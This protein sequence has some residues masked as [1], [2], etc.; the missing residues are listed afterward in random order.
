MTNS[1]HATAFS[2]LFHKKFYTV[3]SGEKDKGINVRIYEFLKKTGLEDRL[4]SDVPES[5]DPNEIEFTNA[6]R[7]ID[8]MRED[9]FRFLRTN[10]QRARRESTVCQ[11]AEDH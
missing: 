9:S 2:I 1:F 10:L 8:R 3:V 7:T 6:D 11:K 5:F 4:F